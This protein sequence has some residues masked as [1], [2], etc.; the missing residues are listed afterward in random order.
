MTASH[1]A[2][3]TEQLRV[4]RL[5]KRIASFNRRALAAVKQLANRVGLT[6]TVDLASTVDLFIQSVS[7]E[8]AKARQTLLTEASSGKFGDCE[9]NFGRRIEELWR[10]RA[11]VLAISLGLLAASTWVTGASHAHASEL[12]SHSSLTLDGAR[13]VIAAVEAKAQ[14]EGWPCAVA[15]VDLSGYLISLDRMD[16]S[17]MLASV[18]LAPEKAKTAALFSKPSKALEDAIHAGRVAA[19][20]AGFVEMEGGLPLTVDGHQVGAVGVSS[21]QPDWDVALA[22]A[23]AGALPSRP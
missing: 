20:T 21:A 19:T 13:K 1:K 5:A 9:M 8:G 2:S 22:A 12:Q 15:V 4:P 6:A 18:Q 14:Q 3:P 17:P 7:W 16:A 11:S 10:R 23:G